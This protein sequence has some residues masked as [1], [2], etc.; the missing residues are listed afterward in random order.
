MGRKFKLR[1]DRKSLQ[2]LQTFKKP[3]G[4]LA[5]WILKIQVLDY[6]FEYFKR[7][8][9]APCDYPSRFLDDTPLEN[10]NEEVKKIKAKYA[11]K[12]K[13]LKIKTNNPVKEEHKYSPL[14]LNN[15]KIYQKKD[16]S[17]L[18]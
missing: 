14:S 18:L 12:N 9:D 16:K 3:T 10:E 17:A 15:I 4:I 1:S 7:K 8:Q 2:Y 5:R 11:P 6:E 13:K